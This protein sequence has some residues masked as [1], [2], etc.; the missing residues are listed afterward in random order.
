[1]TQEE[2]NEYNRLNSCQ[3]DFYN[4]YKKQHPEWEHN[5]LVTMATICGGLPPI[6][7]GEPGIKEILM[8]AVRKADAFLENNFPQIYSKVKN[9]LG[10]IYNNLKNAVKVVWEQFVSWF[11]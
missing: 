10:T 11:N 7:P 4:L 3:K 6:G 2:L 1:M 9:A 8:E 5:Q